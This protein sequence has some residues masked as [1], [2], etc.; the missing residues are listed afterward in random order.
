MKK[1]YPIILAGG[2]GTRLWPLSR[3]SFP[4]QFSNLT[5][6]HTLFQQTALRLVSS[7]FIEFADHIVLTNSD[8]RFIITEQLKAV[9]MKPGSI[10]IEPEAKNTA[11]AILSACLHIIKT[12]PNAIFLVAP[13]D[14]IIRDVSE[15]HRTIFTGLRHVECDKIVTFG[16]PPQGPETGYGYLELECEKLDDK[17]ND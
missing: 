15:F 9:G 10:L 11:P 13:S 4:K 16:V 3:K 7:E 14:H 5:G 1:I 17:G 8:F 6:E 12:D 2:S